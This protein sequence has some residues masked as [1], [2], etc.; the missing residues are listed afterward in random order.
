MSG[1]LDR[2]ARPCFEG[3]S[4]NDERR[5]RKSDFENSEDDRKSRMG[6]LKKKALKASSKFKPNFK[7]KNRRKS[8]DRIFVSIEDVRN[9][10]ELQAV[11]ALRQVLLSDELLPPRHDDYHMLLRFLKARKFDIDKAKSMWANM[12]QWRKEFGTDTILED[13]DFS[14]LDEVLQHYPQGYHGVDKEGRPVYIERLGKVDPYKLTQVTTLDR[15]VRYHVLEFEKCFGIKFP[16]CSVAAKRHIDSSTTIIDVQGVGLKNLT[17]PA[18]EL[19]QRLQKIDSDNYPEV[20]GN[21]YQNKLLEIIDASELPEFLGGDCNCA[22]QGGCMRSNKGPWKDPNILKMVLS[23]ETLCSRQIVTVLNGEGR[24][25][26]RDK[27]RFSMIKG[28]DTSAAESGSEVEEITSPKPTSSYLVPRLTPVSEEPRVVG[29]A[30]STSG[31]PEYDE[32]VPVIDKTV[33]VGWK[34][35]VFPSKSI[36]FFPRVERGPQGTCARIWAMVLAFFTSLITLVCSRALRVNEKDSV[37]DSVQSITKLPVDPLPEEEFHTPSPMLRFTED[38]LTP[39]FRRLGELEEKVDVLQERPYQMPCEKEE[40]LNVAVYR[41]HALEAELI[42]TKKVPERG[43][44]VIKGV[45]EYTLKSKALYEALMRQDELFA[46]MDSQKTKMR[47]LLSSFNCSIYNL[48]TVSPLPSLKFYS[49]ADNNLTR[50][51]NDNT[52]MHP[53]LSRTYQVVVAATR[54]MGIGKDGEL[55]WRLPSDLKFFKELTG[56]YIRSWEEKCYSYGFDTASAEDVVIC[57]SIPSA[58]ELLAEVPY[59]LSIEKV[60]VIGGGQILREGLNAPGCY[61]IHITEIENSIECDTFISAIDLSLFQP[62]Y[63]SQPFVENSIRFSFVTYVRVRNLANGDLIA[64]NKMEWSSSDFNKFWVKKFTFLPKLIF[65]RHEE[66]IYLRL[67]QEIISS[68]NQKRDSTGTDTLSIFGCQMKFNLRRTFPLLTTKN[69][70][71]EGVIEKLLC[72]SLSEREDGDLGPI[73]GLQERHFGA[74]DTNTHADYAGQGYDQLLDVI[75]KIKNRP[76]DKRI[77][78]A[79]WNPSD[80]KLMNRLPCHIFAQFSITNGELSCQMYQ[81]S[82]DMAIG[83]PF[84][85]ASYALL[86]SMI[87]H[88]CDLVPG[89]FIHVIGDAYAY[90]THIRVLQEQLQQ[91]PK[92]FPIL[93]IN[94]EKKDIVSFVASD[95][96]LIGYNPHKMEMKMAV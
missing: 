60:F 48:A 96:E 43:C 13:F 34:K 26:A 87:A 89:D 68:G 29:K 7:K 58:L 78:L 20:L 10:E 50:P 94:P 44:C 80:L 75:D 62:W 28:S 71:W 42:A 35:Q 11:D 93:R 57:K 14:E 83:V 53:P 95:F 49:K 32:Y 92:P 18:R 67:V 33:D 56:D 72:L 82:G 31:F 41:V 63:S 22:D 45:S 59:Y 69:V 66:Y 6:N 76:D 23:G 79:A 46:Y 81:C 30:S 4:S 16:A 86:T 9:V 55:P 3:V 64:R 54:D 65:K 8:D 70:L 47:V 25:I 12:I 90:K 15:Y 91:R 85:I 40:L 19:I 39:V 27:P 61:A 88:V 74:R 24:V 17:K 51:S 5:E 37:S 38:T 2:L 77:I 73:D 36:L 1:S 21:K 84:N 52:T